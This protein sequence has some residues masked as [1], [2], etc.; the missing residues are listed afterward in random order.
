MFRRLFFGQLVLVLLLAALTGCR[1]FRPCPD[2]VERTTVRDSLIYVQGA[3][4]RDTIPFE[5]VRFDTLT[6]LLTIRVTDTVHVAEADGVR[7]ETRITP[8]G[9][10]TKATRTDTVIKTQVVE[11]ER[12]VLVDPEERQWAWW[13]WFAA[14]MVAAFV[15]IAIWKLK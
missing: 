9:I 15:L 6:Q 2:V 13:K 12:I 4:I 5:T 10:E 1:V 8:Q 7:V 11:R 3:T 14:G